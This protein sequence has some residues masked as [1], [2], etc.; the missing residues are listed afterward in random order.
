MLLLCTWQPVLC[1]WML[2]R[3]PLLLTSRLTLK[4]KP[5]ISSVA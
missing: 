1:S 4:E 2:T 5:R 3:L